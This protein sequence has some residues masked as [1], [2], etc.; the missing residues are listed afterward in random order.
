[1]LSTMVEGLQLARLTYRHALKR[2]GQRAR[3][4][5]ISFIGMLQC[6]T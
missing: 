2:S 3:L 4:G 5:Y 6:E 1:M